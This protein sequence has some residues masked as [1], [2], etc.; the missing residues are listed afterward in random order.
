[1]TNV[2][3]QVL[4][5]VL[6]EKFE[7]LK[8]KFENNDCKFDQKIYN[9]ITK[10]LQ[11]QRYGEESKIVNEI[12]DIF[13]NNKNLTKVYAKVLIVN[14]THSTRINGIHCIE[15]AK[16]IVKFD[17]F[18][19]FDERLKNGDIKLVDELIEQTYENEH[20]KKHLWSF[21]PKYLACHNDKFSKY[22]HYVGD[23][24]EKRSKLLGLEKFEK[25]IG[26]F[27]EN[28]HN[29]ITEI[30]NKDGFPDRQTFDTFIWALYRK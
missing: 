22:D 1:M 17:K 16:D 8:E 7:N 23:Y 30:I 14:T 10:L 18:N 6:K 24:V 15:V 5:E 9:E 26:K 21:Y 11:Q 20:I 28:Y 25:R 29:A 13:P 2:D 12:I 19:K 3:K 4:K 27:Y